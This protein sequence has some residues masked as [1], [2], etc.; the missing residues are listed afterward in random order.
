[1]EDCF[2]LRLSDKK[3]CKSL[4][5]KNGTIIDKITDEI[6]LLLPFGLKPSFLDT[7]L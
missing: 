5:L 4:Q 3:M 1:M 2:K 7:S 6:T